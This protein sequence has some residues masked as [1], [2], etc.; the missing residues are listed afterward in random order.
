M[1]QDIYRA[2]PAELCEEIEWL[3]AKLTALEKA[4]RHLAQVHAEL[5][6]HPVAELLREAEKFLAKS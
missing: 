3:R 1:L 6:G 2:R 4:H 5:S